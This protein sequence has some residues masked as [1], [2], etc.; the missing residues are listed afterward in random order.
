MKSKPAVLEISA[1]KGTRPNGTVPTLEVSENRVVETSGN[2]GEFESSTMVLL[3][4]YTAETDG[5]RRPRSFHMASRTDFTLSDTFRVAG[6]SCMVTLEED[7]ISWVPRKASGKKEGRL[8]TM[9][10]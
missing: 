8:H 6:K 2:E 9:L 5:D 3:R 7:H 10:V 1:E 4:R